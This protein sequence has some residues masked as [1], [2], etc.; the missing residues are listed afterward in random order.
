MSTTILSAPR[1]ATANVHGTGCTLS[2][3]IAAHLAGLAPLAAIRAAKH[4]VTR[5]LQGGAGW[6]V[7][8]GHGPLD[9]M[10]WAGRGTA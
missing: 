1:V 6:S 2:A 4:Y 9:H 7:G 5:A 10:G 8:T 3:G